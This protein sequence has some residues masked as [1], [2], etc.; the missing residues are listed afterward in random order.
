MTATAEQQAPGCFASASVYGADSVVCQACPA[1]AGCGEESVK[2][3]QEIRQLVDVTDLLARH[4]AARARVA[5][6]L[7]PPGKKKP[8]EPST[9]PVSQAPA[10]VQ[11]LERTTPM[12]KTVHSISPEDQATIDMLGTKN[13]KA[14]EQAI[15]L[16]K[17]G[18][19]DDMRSLLPVQGNPFAESGPKYLRVACDMLM[20]GGFTKAQFKMQLVSELKWGDTTAASHVALAC[21]LLYSFKIAVPD[22]SGAFVINP[23]LYCDNE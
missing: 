20:R 21:A 16:C 3:L 11:P 18:K 22:S 19:V 13:L 4:K 17:N 15:V 12:V 5:H 6:R 8:V 2:T 7:S 1:Y 23:A 9:V 10:I 14:R